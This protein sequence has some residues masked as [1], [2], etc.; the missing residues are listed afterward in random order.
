MP[1]HSHGARAPGPGLTGIWP[2]VYATTLR[3][4]SDRPLNKAACWRLRC[5]M[6][7]SVGGSPLSLPKTC[8]SAIP[9]RQN[10]WNGRAGPRARKCA[11]LAAA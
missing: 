10:R 1:P 11:L 9:P 6:L 3:V 7:L 2:G 5:W 4:S 8:L